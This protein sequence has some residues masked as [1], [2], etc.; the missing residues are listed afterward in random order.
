MPK[1]DR[2]TEA[3]F[4]R[5]IGPERAEAI[6]SQLNGGPV[7][8]DEDAVAEGE[9]G[10]PRFLRIPV[11]GPSMNVYW[12]IGTDGAPHLTTA[13]RSFKR[14]VAQF[15][16]HSRARPIVG[17]VEMTIHVY[18]TDRQRDTDNNL[19]PILD[20]LEGCFVYEKDN[21]V[22]EIHIRRFVDKENPRIEIWARPFNTVTVDLFGG[23]AARIEGE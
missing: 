21:V 4:L 11:L 1:K 7:R 17:L 8:A 15:G 10:E 16:S 3:A 6:R 14:L 9:T 2:W 5:Q 19:K 13:G 22:E 23:G 12:R 20:A 18:Q